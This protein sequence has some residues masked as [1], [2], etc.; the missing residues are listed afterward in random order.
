MAEAQRLFGRVDSSTPVV[1]PTPG[2]DVATITALHAQAAEVHNIR[3]LVPVVLDP[4][5][6][7]FAR[8]RD[9]VLLTLQRYALTDH[10]IGDVVAP[11]DPDGQR[12]S[13]VAH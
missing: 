1:H 9:E 13:L 8:L 2:L 6:P 3:S 10:V 5:S 7:H 4:A 11:L 12:R